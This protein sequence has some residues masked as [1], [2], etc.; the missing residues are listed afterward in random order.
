MDRTRSMLHSSIIGESSD[1]S[2]G[3]C[4]VFISTDTEEN[5]IENVVTNVTGTNIARDQS[6]SVNNNLDNMEKDSSKYVVDDT[7]E[8]CSKDSKP[9]RT[10]NIDSD[11]FEVF[12]QHYKLEPWIEQGACFT[13]V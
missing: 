7:K 2:S 10:S 9:K 11:D 5:T 4:V 3:S 6:P 1:D 8:G 12:E 13:A